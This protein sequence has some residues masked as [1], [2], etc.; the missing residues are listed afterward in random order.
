MVR[1]APVEGEQSVGV[2]ERQ[3]GRA[4]QGT[5]MAY[6]LRR[7]GRAQPRPQRLGG[8]PGGVQHLV[9]GPLGG[10]G[11]AA[12]GTQPQHRQQSCGQRGYQRDD[13]DDGGEVATHAAILA[14][15]GRRAKP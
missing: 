15:A 11:D 14:P 12:T 1:A 8:Q 2:G 4:H 13:A 9:G 6:G 5:Q 3:P 7:A 10:G